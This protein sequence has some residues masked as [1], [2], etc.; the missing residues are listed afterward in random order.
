MV[1]VWALSLRWVGLQLQLLNVVAGTRFK[2]I[3]GYGTTEQRLAV[4]RGEVDGV[5]GR[6]A[7]VGWSHLAADFAGCTADGC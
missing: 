7:R 3:A 2:V 1:I 6:G 4:E 5:C